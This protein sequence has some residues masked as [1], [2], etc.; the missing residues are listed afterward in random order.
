[1]SEHNN[2]Q[3]S[4]GKF[5]WFTGVIVDINDPQKASRVKVRIHGYHNQDTNELPDDHLQW[6]MVM[7]SPFSASTNGIGLTPHGL[8]KDAHVIGF[9]L[10]GESSQLPMVIGSFPAMNNGVPDVNNLARGETIQK[11]LDTNSLFSEKSSGASPIYPYNKV[12]K[13]TSGHTIELDDTDSKERIHVYHKSGTFVEFHPDGSVVHKIKGESDLIV[14]KDLNIHIKGNTN[15]LIDGN[16]QETINGDKTTN[17]KGKY[18]VNCQAYMMKTIA[19][20]TTSIGSSGYVK[21]TGTYT[22][23]SATIFLN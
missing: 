10:D 5:V 11:Q 22:V 15:I 8:I 20:W 17:I 18:I 4:M 7:T 9:F 23:K 1:M 21:A 6:A 2:N 19:T 14:D 16:V 13:T 12:L 3:F